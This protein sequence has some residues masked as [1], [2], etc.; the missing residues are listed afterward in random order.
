MPIKRSTTCQKPTIQEC[1]AFSKCQAH[2]VSCDVCQGLDVPAWR[3][4]V[5]MVLNPVSGRGESGDE[6][7]SSSTGFASKVPSATKV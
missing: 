6:R 4:H 3:E 5:H 7:P 2:K 1:P